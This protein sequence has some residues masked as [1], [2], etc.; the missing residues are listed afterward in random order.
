MIFKKNYRCQEYQT[1][2]SIHTKKIATP[3]GEISSELFQYSYRSLDQIIIRF[4]ESKP[5]SKLRNV[6]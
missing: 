6:G 5:I 1:V 3:N 4:N 2:S